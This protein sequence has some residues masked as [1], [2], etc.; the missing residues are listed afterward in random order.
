MTVIRW[1]NYG[2]APGPGPPRIVNGNR[3]SVAGDTDLFAHK[4]QTRAGP[5]P[6]AGAPA[7]AAPKTARRAKV[8]HPPHAGGVAYCESV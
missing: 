6:Q 3:N 8:G 4:Y 7:S 5:R 1:V 2:E